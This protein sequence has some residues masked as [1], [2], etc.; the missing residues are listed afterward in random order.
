MLRNA[1]Y[2][3]CS[4]GYKIPF[5]DE[6]GK[7]DINVYIPYKD[8]KKSRLNNKKCDLCNQKLFTKCFIQIICG[9]TFHFNCFRS[10]IINRCI[11]EKSPIICCPNHLELKNFDKIYDEIRSTHEYV[12]PGDPKILILKEKI[13]NF[14][15]DRS[16][17][18][19]NDLNQLEENKINLISQ[20]YK[21]EIEAIDK[22]FKFYSKNLYQEITKK[23]KLYKYILARIYSIDDFDTETFID[24]VKKKTNNTSK[25]NDIKTFLKPIKYRQFY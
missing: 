11:Y 1:K 5:K 13:Q 23:L 17:N 21:E 6:K 4:K 22:H 10:Y 7:T 12:Y 25:L 2:K 9:D 20:Q 18:R 8:H 16:Y 3:V 14:E 15:I 24:L 19:E